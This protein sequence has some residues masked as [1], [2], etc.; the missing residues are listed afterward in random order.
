MAIASNRRAEPVVSVLCIYVS[1]GS[2]SCYLRA[3]SSV[4]WDA[5]IRLLFLLI[6]G[7]V[8]LQA[9]I[10]AAGNE[11]IRGFTGRIIDI[12]G[13]FARVA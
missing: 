9:E 6:V 3:S 10:A 13:R 8:A 12:V 4:F 5:G 2:W 1:V 7:L 11:K